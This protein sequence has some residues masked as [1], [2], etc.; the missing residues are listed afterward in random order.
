MLLVPVLPYY[1]G[2]RPAQVKE[3]FRIRARIV[4]RIQRWYRTRTEVAAMR[5]RIMSRISTYLSI[6]AQLQ[7]RAAPAR[8]PPG[9]V[10]GFPTGLRLVPPVYL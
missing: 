1:G 3:R 4:Q 8:F 5:R 9:G 10:A 2:F 6:A 7:V